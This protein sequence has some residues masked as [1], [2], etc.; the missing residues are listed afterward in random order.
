M[1]RLLHCA[2]QIV[3]L[4][5]NVYKVCL[6]TYVIFLLA[7]IGHLPSRSPDVILLSAGPL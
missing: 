2:I 5:T 4:L 3:G 6:F 7:L 1:P